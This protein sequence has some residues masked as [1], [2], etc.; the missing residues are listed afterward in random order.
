MSLIKVSG[1]WDEFFAVFGDRSNSHFHDFASFQESSCC[2]AEPRPMSANF[3]VYFYGF[4][5][6]HLHQPFQYCKLVACA[7]LKFQ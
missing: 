2:H 6:I 7:S 1:L 5:P 3:K 4:K